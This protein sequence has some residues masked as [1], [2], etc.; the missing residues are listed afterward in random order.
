MINVV[1]IGYS[2]HSYVVYD[3]LKS[4]G[5]EVTKYCDSGLKKTN[6]LSLDYLG[7]ELDD[8]ALNYIKKNNFFTSIG[9][10]EIRSRVFKYLLSNVEYKPINAIHK[11]AILSSSI[12]TGSGVMIGPGVIIN[13]LSKL[14]DGVICNSGSIIEHGVELGKFV[15]LAP[16]STLCGNVKVGDHS[17]IGANSVI[18]QGVTIGKNVVIGAGAVVVSDVK[19]DSVVIGNP[20][21]PI[22]NE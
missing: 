15:H 10:N 3:C 14:G 9:N 11:S 8:N 1:L 7:G 20:A 17:F 19:N 18:K 5:H 16:G 13:A 6:L 12:E 21:K 2:G 22:I 4:S